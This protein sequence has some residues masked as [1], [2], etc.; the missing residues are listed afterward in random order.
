M[1]GKPLYSLFTKSVGIVTE[2]NS[3]HNDTNKRNNC[4]SLIWALK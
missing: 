1:E 3:D 4:L 2:S